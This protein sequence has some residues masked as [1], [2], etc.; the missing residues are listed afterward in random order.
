MTLRRRNLAIAIPMSLVLLAVVLIVAVDGPQAD[1]PKPPAPSGAEERSEALA[2]FAIVADKSRTPSDAAKVAKSISPPGQTLD[3][4]GVRLA[5]A[6]NPTIHVVAADGRLCLKVI[7]TNRTGGAG[8]TDP[9]KVDG[10]YALTGSYSKVSDGQRLTLL[11]PEGVTGL[12]VTQDGKRST[13]DVVNN[14]ATRLMSDSPGTI[15][16]INDRGEPQS[17]RMS[18][19]NE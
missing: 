11:V 15:E 6:E 14:V 2:K 17:Q 1:T 19:A 3:P 4:S 13:L 12:T 16:W 9:A 7:E 5:R 18:G 10:R 8:C